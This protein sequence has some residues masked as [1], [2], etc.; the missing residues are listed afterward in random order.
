MELRSRNLES[1]LHTAQTDISERKKKKMLVLELLKN[2]K[3][4]LSVIFRTKCC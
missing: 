2:Y 4:K 3:L 1:I